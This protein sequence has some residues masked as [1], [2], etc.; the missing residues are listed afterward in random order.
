MCIIKDDISG[1]YQKIIDS[2]AIIIGFPIY[3][4]RE[5]AQLRESCDD[6]NYMKTVQK[7]ASEKIFYPNGIKEKQ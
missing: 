2:D 4:G 5:C 7:K 3:T 1:I 6:H